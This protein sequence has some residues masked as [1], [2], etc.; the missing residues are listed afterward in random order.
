M[1]LVVQYADH[2]SSIVG[3]LS[4]PK[5]PDRGDVK[6]PC[7]DAAVDTWPASSRHC[8][9]LSGAAGPGA[10]SCATP[11]SSARQAASNKRAAHGALWRG[12]GDGADADRRKAT[13][14][15]LTRGG[16][17]RA[18]MAVVLWRG[19]GETGDRC[20]EQCASAAVE[21]QAAEG[22]RMSWRSFALRDLFRDG[23]I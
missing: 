13:E 23:A 22:G 21:A 6:L 12:D 20:G 16:R 5:R 15:L 9:V 17:R 11:S 8:L 3:S 1:S 4:R 14:F 10:G 7:D 19:R 18:S 2:S